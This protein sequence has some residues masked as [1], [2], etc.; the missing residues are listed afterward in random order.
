MLAVQNTSNVTVRNVTIDGTG[1]TCPAD[2]NRVVGIELTN[3][4]DS[5]WSSAA[6]TVDNSVVRNLAPCDIADGIDSEYSGVTINANELHDLGAHCIALTGG[7]MAITN[8]RIQNC[9]MDGILMT[10]GAST[11]LIQGN[12]VYAPRGIEL[13][14]TTTNVKVTSNVIGPFTGIGIL[15][16]QVSNIQVSNNQVNASYTGVWMYRGSGTNIINNTIANAQYGLVNDSPL[17]G[18]INSITSNTVNEALIGM[19]LYN[20]DGSGDFVA[21]NSFYN[22]ATTISPTF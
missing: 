5:T 18:N 3:L 9:H 7:L 10:D 17:G 4:G 21:P 12:N 22:C 6:A 13:G 15:L 14:G 2:A 8:N 19:V 16:V 20:V 11:S 1:S